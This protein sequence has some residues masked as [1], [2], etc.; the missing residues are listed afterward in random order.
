MAKKIIRLTEAD[1]T[2][3]IKR[4]IQ[5][6][7]LTPLEQGLKDTISKLPSNPGVDGIKKI[8]TFCRS[9]PNLISPERSFSAT[10]LF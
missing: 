9:P 8:T 1:L 5:E 7:K 4:V 2:R 3:I 10:S 6:Q